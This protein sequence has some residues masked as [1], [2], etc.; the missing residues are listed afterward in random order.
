MPRTQISLLGRFRL[1]DETGREIAVAARRAQLLLALLALQAPQPV[2]R[3]RVVG[4][5]WGEL[6]EE[7]ARHS[8]R[9]LLT[10]LRKHAHVVKASGEEIALDTDAC[11]VDLVE[12]R[13]LAARGD[14][15][16]LQRMLELYR[17]PLL[18]GASADEE[19]LHVERKR[20]ADLAA[21]AASRLATRYTEAGDHVAAVQMLR[22]W[23]GADPCVE[24]AHRLLM[25]SLNAMGERTAA[26]Q[27][28]QR[29]VDALQRE[30][31]VAPSAET[32]ALYRSLR[33]ASSGVEETQA[34]GGLPCVAVLPVVNF[35][36]DAELGALCV[37]LSEDLSSQLARL[38][39]FEV[40]ADRAVAAAAQ[41]AGS[42]IRRV[43]RA[44]RA[45]YLVT[46]SLRRLDEGTLRVAIQLL[47]GDSAQ[48][49]WTE[50]TDLP[51][52]PKQTQL[53]EFL[54][55]IAAKL[56]QRLTVEASKGGEAPKD[57]WD[58]LRRASSVLFSRGWSEEAVMEAIALY[59]QAVALDPRLALARAQKGLIIALSERWGLI[60]G[61]ELRNEAR[62]DV[63]HALAMDPNK[64]EVLGYAGCAIADLGDP[65]RAIPILERAVQE[66][67]GNAQA[68]AALGATQLLLR[69]FEAGVESLRHGLRI[70]PTDYRRSVWQTAL[71]G[72]LT[73]LKQYEEAAEMAQA[74]CRSDVNFYAAR[75][76][77]AAALVK[78]GRESAAAKALAEAKRLRPQLTMR[79]VRFWV[80]NRSLDRFDAQLTV[81][82]T[83]G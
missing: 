20:L 39:G 24:E 23:L 76:M 59:R 66:N 71:A 61:E 18:D 48:Y 30:L 12:F 37:A 62:A 60:H 67:P 34:V 50:L 54:A 8:L 44:L 58:A 22:R 10:T 82:R 1:K 25:R 38:P 27:Q 83:A 14:A 3:E 72:G 64:S 46:G 65:A 35:T 5:L 29:C 32:A 74:A 79:E 21:G 41:E 7:R 2:A 6:S 75:I 70:S 13:N 52:R 31:G 49:L 69:R 11:S 36:R 56:E 4:L 19:W 40:L 73:R 47:E 9:Q 77:L 63:E 26:L 81:S 53:D 33:D 51:A 68:W 55:A 15:Q 42:D 17:G 28:Y 16:S 57:A 45:R 43:A 78:L 80:G